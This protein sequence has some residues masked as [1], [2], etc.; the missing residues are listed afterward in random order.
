MPF[1]FFFKRFF[2]TSILFSDGFGHINTCINE[3]M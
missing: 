2:V 1:F 3:L